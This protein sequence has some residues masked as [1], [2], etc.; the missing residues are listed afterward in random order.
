MQL[1]KSHTGA[2]LTARAAVELNTLSPQDFGQEFSQEMS[3][4]IIITS[5]SGSF[6]SIKILLSDVF[7]QYC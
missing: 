2:V 3:T 4:I 6:I 5:K 7:Y 1:S